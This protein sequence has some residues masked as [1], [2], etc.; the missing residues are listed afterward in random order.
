[1]PLDPEQLAK[2]KHAY[3]VFDLPITASSL[4]IKQ[5]YRALT[6]RWHPDLYSSGSPEQAEATQMMK[7]VNDAYALI[8][9]APLRYY[10]EPQPANREPHTRE[11]YV[12]G[13]GR[14][15][16]LSRRRDTPPRFDA[17]EFWVRFSCGVILGLLIC[18]AQLLRY[19]YQYQ[20]F[21][22]GLRYGVL[23]V[24]VMLCGVLLLGMAAALGGDDFWRY[25]L[26]HLW[27]WW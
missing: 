24:G 20:R 9:S 1:M 25:R 18:G 21:D 8:A 13:T 27:W 5:S 16:D 23:S 11:P 7:I 10:D 17:W 3:Q 22:S 14:P 2:L 6:K 15:L 26:R 12:A 19:F 4:K